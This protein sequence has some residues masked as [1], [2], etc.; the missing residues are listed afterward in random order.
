M[1]T[2]R[3]ILKDTNRCNYCIHYEP[4]RKNGKTYC[5]GKCRVTG[6]YKQRTENCKRHF[7]KGVQLGLFSKFE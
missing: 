1:D 5:R 4:L 7:I 3:K 2:S 6:R